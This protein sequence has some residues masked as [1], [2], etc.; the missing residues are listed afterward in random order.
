M[1]RL[2][3]KPSDIRVKTSVNGRNVDAVIDTAADVTVISG[4]LYNS[5]KNRPKLTGR[6]NLRAEAEGQ[7]FRASVTEAVCIQIGS[8][9][10]FSVLFVAPIQDNMLLGIDL[11]RKF[12]ATIDLKKG[13]FMVKGEKIL[14]AQH[15]PVSKGFDV[16]LDRKIKC[17]PLSTTT[18]RIPVC[19]DFHNAILDFEPNNTLPIFIPAAIFE[20]TVEV[21]IHLTNSSRNSISLCKG[22]SLGYLST[23]DPD[24]I[25]N[26]PI[27]AR[28]SIPSEDCVLPEKLTT[29]LK[30]LLETA[31]NE[32]TDSELRSLKQ[33]LFEYSDVFAENDLDLGDFSAISHSIDTGEAPPVKCG[34]RRT[35]IHFVQEEDKLLNEM[36]IAGVIRPSFSSWAAA[37]VFVR[38]RDGRTRWCLDYRKLNACT[39][40]DVYPVPMMSEC[41]DALD[42]NVWFSKLDANSAYWQIPVEEASKEKTAFR[43]RQGLF[44]F[45]KLPFG[46]CNAPST[47]C[48]AINIVLTGL[49]W[50]KVLAFVDDICVLGGSVS[51]HLSNLKLVFER[52]RQY[53][54]KLK[55]SKCYLFKREIE[56]LGRKIGGDGMTLTDHSIA[57]IEKWSPPK[58]V[59]EVERFLGLVNFHRMFI[60]GYSKVCEPLFRLL[61]KKE[62]IWGDEQQEAFSSVKEI[63]ASPAVLA[64]PSRNGRFILDTDASNVAI[65]AQLR[66]EQDGTERVIAY[67]SFALTPC[68]RKYC[69]TRKE[70]L[71]VVRFTNHFRHYL[72]GSEF[73]VRTDHH[74]LIWLLNFKKLEGQL[75]RWHE[76]LSRFSM[77]VQHRP[78]KHHQNADALSRIPVRDLV[79]TN[80]QHE[81]PLNELP[82]G[83]CDY[84]KRMYSNWNTFESHVDDVVELISGDVRNVGLDVSFESSNNIRNINTHVTTSLDQIAELQQKDPELKFLYEWLTTSAN[85]K[86]EELKLSS[87]PTKF[88]WINRQMCT[89]KG[90]VVYWKGQQQDFVIVPEG[91]KDTILHLCHDLPSSG[92]QGIEGTKNR[93]KQRYFWYSINSDVRNYVTG[94]KLCNI[95][96]YPNRKNKCP[97]TINQAGYPLEKVHIDFMGPFPRTI[98]GNVHLLVIVDSFTKWC[99]LIPLPSQEAEVTAWAVVKEFFLKFGC[100][101]EIVSDQGRNF[102][103]ALFREV[104]ELFRVHKLRTT[105]Y[106]PSA[107]GQSERMNRTLLQALRCFVNQKQ[108]NWD[109]CV[110][111]IAS[112][113]RS[114]VN[115][116]TGFTPNKL[117]LGREVTMPAELIFPCESRI[118]S[119]CPTISDFQDQLQEAHDMARTTLKVKTK[120]MKRDYDLGVHRISFLK[121]DVV[122]MLDKTVHKGL[123]SKLGPVWTGPCLI[124]EVLSPYLFRVQINNRL[125]KVVNHDRLKKCQDK[126]IPKWMTK[127]K[128]ELLSGAVN[129]YCFCGL[130]DDGRIMI[131]CDSCF[132]WYHGHCVG[133]DKNKA[134]TL[135]E[136]LCNRCT[137]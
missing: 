132:E 70:L 75:A 44:E 43:T 61:K 52:F 114:S 96:K 92:H 32:F 86:N 48:R 10:I 27:L 124:V 135:K 23:L 34:L 50:S 68:Q 81:I 18:V 39:K 118:V 64:V 31:S 11:L 30:N 29:L 22:T 133:V 125:T 58:T 130:P 99:E 111:F 56:F 59:K 62:F 21:P 54:L 14:L 9:Q 106:R 116:Q 129:V 4:S 28:V 20:Q 100:P 112:A 57:T 8:A 65:G 98:D 121:G 79:C 73:V 113:I 126:E 95:N 67:A 19:V 74:S 7:I 105:A 90:G 12:Q 123:S 76:E 83:G 87:K 38:K 71:A 88:Y 66:Q 82:C 13:I 89:L 131:Q 45:N 93:V 37:P 33:L 47:Y 94:C 77:T 127:R 109:K 6:V 24:S 101:L 69:T 128:V 41:L 2:K 55:P 1:S 103:S 136:Y 15:Y 40:K 84:C 42:G 35:P 137:N 3:S 91:L 108:T 36:L 5:M 134:K 49:T 80:Y 85:P 51:D 16:K 110:P 104:C 53:H 115:K 72:L 102:E 117:M 78:G 60:P 26:S 17:P 63:L 119:E 122:Y 25:E 120:Q 97:L 107:N 46:L